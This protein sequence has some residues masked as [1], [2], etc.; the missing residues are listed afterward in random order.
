VA[1]ENLGSIPCKFHDVPIEA[2]VRRDRKGK[3]YIYCDEC[4]ITSPRAA[5]FQEYIHKNMKPFD[6]VRE[7]GPVEPVQQVKHKTM[8]EELGL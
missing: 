6:A 2:H 1:N 8:A 7:A 4:G 5:K 3:L